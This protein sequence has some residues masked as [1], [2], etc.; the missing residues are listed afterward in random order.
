MARSW[1]VEYLATVEFK[2]AIEDT[3]ATF[4]DRDEVFRERGIED[5]TAMVKATASEYG[6]PVQQWCG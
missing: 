6:D 5:V 3:G 1:D 4:C 2:E